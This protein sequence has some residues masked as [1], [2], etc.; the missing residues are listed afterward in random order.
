MRFR[1]S[2]RTLD[3]FSRKKIT[4]TAEK[5]KLTE[6]HPSAVLLNDMHQ[7]DLATL[8]WTD[9]SGTFGPNSDRQPTPRFL[10]YIGYAKHAIDSTHGHGR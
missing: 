7:F 3:I 9:L 10:S 2:N 8:T 6:A 5:W 4:N 1:F